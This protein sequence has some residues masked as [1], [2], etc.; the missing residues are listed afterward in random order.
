MRT[1]NTKPF[2]ILWIEY[3]LEKIEAGQI[4]LVRL[5][6]SKSGL[7]R[8]KIEIIPAGW[9]NE[10]VEKLDAMRKNP[11]DLIILDFMLPRTEEA[12]RKEPPLVDPN[13]GYML[14][15]RLRKG[16]DWGK[17]MQ[18]VPIIFI[19]ALS[20]PVYRPMM[21]SDGN[22]KWLEK[23]IFPSEIVEVIKHRV[24]AGSF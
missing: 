13:A 11:P 17:D 23:P 7:N 15:H 16:M 24:E 21:E 14:W 19:T 2:R 5:L 1:S 6:K 18:Q 12:F 20:R 9:V 10:A 8:K 4:E 3:E 22:L